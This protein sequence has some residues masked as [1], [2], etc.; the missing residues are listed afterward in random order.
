MAII[1]IIAIIA[2]I[3]ITTIIIIIILATRLAGYEASFKNCSATTGSQFPLSTLRRLIIIF[4]IMIIMM[5]MMAIAILI[6]ILMIMVFCSPTL[7]SDQLV[8]KIIIR[9]RKC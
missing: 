4:M 1:V 7:S 6:M 5:T 2:I 8:K 3:T 9:S